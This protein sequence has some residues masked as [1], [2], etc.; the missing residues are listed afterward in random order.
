MVNVAV[1]PSALIMPAALVQEVNEK[2]DIEEPLT[3]MSVATISVKSKVDP[4]VALI[5]IVPCA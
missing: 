5:S 2:S 4:G 1:L 3:W